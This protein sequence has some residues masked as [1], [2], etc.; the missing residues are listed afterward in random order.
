MSGAIGVTSTD[1]KRPGDKLNTVEV[2]RR[3]SD[4][5][6]HVSACG[7]V[8]SPFDSHT[9]TAVEHEEFSPGCWPRCRLRRWRFLHVGIVF[10]CL[11]TF[12]RVSATAQTGA[13]DAH[14]TPRQTAGTKTDTGVERD[15]RVRVG[16]IVKDV[17]LVLVPVT[18]TDDIGRPVTGLDKQNFAVYEAQAKQQVQYF[19]TEDAPIS[20]GILFDASGS[21]S[22]KIEEARKAIGEFFKTANPQDEFFVIAFADRPKLISDFDS[23][24]EDIQSKLMLVAPKG[25]TALHDAIYLGLSKASQGHYPRRAL[26][27]ISDGGD[28]HSRYSEREVM[29]FARE[30]DTPIYA[31]GIHS[32][33]RAREEHLGSWMLGKMTEA[34]GGRHF[35]IER[36]QDLAD[37]TTKIGYIL[38]NRYVLG[39]RPG[40][41]VHDGKWRKIKVRLQLPKE[42]PHLA[43]YAKTGY[44]APPK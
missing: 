3:A 22:D 36:P 14:I 29:T 17:N 37:V 13:E 39:Y 26:L 8:S 12:W 1:P 43:I 6:V 33:P 23:S 11:V 42:M 41:P 24:P 15:A 31:I 21:M 27:I 18:V 9:A 34:T 25:A 5:V 19:S 32:A 4:G 7:I 35:T 2:F 40:N 30:A 16:S 38:R 10:V 44:Y 28:N 20:V